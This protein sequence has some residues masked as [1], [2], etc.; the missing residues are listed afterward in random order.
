MSSNKYIYEVKVLIFSGRP[1]PIWKLNSQE[2]DHIIEIWDELNRTEKIFEK[3]PLLGYRG[4]TI[5]Q[6]DNIVFFAYQGIIKKEHNNL[7]E[8][9]IDPQKKFEQYLIN[10]SPKGLLPNNILK[11]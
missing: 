10:T 6:H 3:V 5:S 4:I 1:D 7:T 2:V 8:F 11:F 9:R